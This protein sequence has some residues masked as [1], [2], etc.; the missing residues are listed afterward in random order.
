MKNDDDSFLESGLFSKHITPYLS[1]QFVFV[2][3]LS[4]FIINTESF[5]IELFQSRR[6]TMNMKKILL[7]IT[8]LMVSLSGHLLLSTPVLGAAGQVDPQPTVTIS[9]DPT[10]GYAP[11][12]VSFIVDVINPYGDSVKVTYQWHFGDGTATTKKDPA[13][14]FTKRN[15]YNVTCRVTFWRTPK[16]KVDRSIQIEVFEEQQSFEYTGNFQ[17]FTVPAR[18]KRIKFKIWGAGGGKGVYSNYNAG[19]AGGYTSGEMAVN[20]GD[21]YVIVVGQGG[22]GE[23]IARYGSGGDV[24]FGGGGYGTTGDAPGA[25]GGGLSGIFSGTTPISFD[26]A[27][28][29]RAIAIAGGGGGSCAYSSGGGGGGGLAGLSTN[30]G[31]GGTQT[32]GGTETFGA[33]GSALKGGNGDS[34]GSRTEVLLNPGPGLNGGYDGGG[35]GG[36]YFGGEGGFND[37]QPGGG[38]SGFIN[39][40]VINGQ[41][42]AGES[43]PQQRAAIP[44]NNSDID[45][46][47]GIGVGGYNTGNANGG[48]GLVII[49]W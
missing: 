48:N 35:G 15:M 2:T 3:L 47:Q 36:G 6:K 5:L 29:A 46:R 45:Y 42:I 27:G 37:A 17:Y 43:G 23:G 21:Q 1:L 16:V 38:G 30:G 13:H 39:T 14:T 28:Q 44:P 24:T 41:T 49:Y 25:S 26:A 34:R 32:S 7:F 22:I 4:S 33:D 20:P 19:G 31:K 9:A 40:I 11:L 8:A 10:F 18:V 12:N